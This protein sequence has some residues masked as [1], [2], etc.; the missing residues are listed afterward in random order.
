MKLNGVEILLRAHNF[1][2]S[3]NKN[4]GKLFSNKLSFNNHNSNLLL[5]NF[6]R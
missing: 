3:K 5:S 2:I 6:S 4:M 1:L